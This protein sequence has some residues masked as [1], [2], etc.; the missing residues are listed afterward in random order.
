MCMCMYSLVQ[1]RTLFLSITAFSFKF[2]SLDLDDTKSIDADEFYKEIPTRR[3]FNMLDSNKDDQLTHNELLR[4]I[5][6]LRLKLNELK[7]ELKTLQGL[8]EIVEESEED[9][10]E[11]T[12]TSDP[13]LQKKLM[14]LYKYI[15]TNPQTE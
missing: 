9:V 4:S 11:S 5:D 12:D 8:E 13:V 10:A 2:N 15:M 14:E 1:S 7:K 3:I 6:G